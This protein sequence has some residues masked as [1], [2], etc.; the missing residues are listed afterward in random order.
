MLSQIPLRKFVDGRHAVLHRVREFGA[1]VYV[2]CG[3]S[4]QHTR[5]AHVLPLHR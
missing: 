4:V 1:A 3:V 2:L 5:A